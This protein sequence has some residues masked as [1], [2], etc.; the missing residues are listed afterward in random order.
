MYEYKVVEQVQRKKKSMSGVLRIVIAFFAVIFVLMGIIISQ[1]F[2]LAGFLL[3]GL[4]FVYDV[5]SQK[6]Y[7]YT[8]EGNHLTIDIIYGKKYRKT[9]H[10]LDMADMEVTAPSGHEA[11]KRYK[12][13]TGEEKL[14]KYDYTS[15]DDQIPYY[16]MITW[17]DGKKIKLLL[18]LNNNMLHIL[19]HL[20]PERVYFA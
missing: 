13:I 10:E 20:C 2:M 14:K 3:T 18:D 12:K 9:A 16:T 15:Y 7:E 4:Y 8:M 19:K 11:V 6:E 5:L 1:A 17:E